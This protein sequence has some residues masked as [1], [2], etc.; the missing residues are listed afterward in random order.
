MSEQQTVGAETAPE[1]T[2]Q[3]TTPEVDWKAK[4]REWERRAKE[5]KAAADKLAEL[6]QAKLT[7]EERAAQQ[8]TEATGRADTLAK[9]NLRLRVALQKGLPADL[10]DRLRGDSEDEIAAD[11]DHLMSLFPK[12]TEPDTSPA[13]RPDLTQGSGTAT[14]L[15][16]DPLLRDLK[17]KLGIA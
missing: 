5:N 10:I 8:L 17:Q 7:A 6:E 11:A 4:S 13:P 16:G 1:A 14:A 3:Q 2:D 15:N 12:Q 9:D